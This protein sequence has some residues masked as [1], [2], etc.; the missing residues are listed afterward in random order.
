[1][2]DG[3]GEVWTQHH[4][5]RLLHACTTTAMQHRRTRSVN[6]HTDAVSAPP[7]APPNPPTA[8]PQLSLS[9]LPVAALSR[10]A[11]HYGLISNEPLTPAQATYPTPALPVELTLANSSYA[12]QR[13]RSSMIPDRLARRAGTAAADLLNNGVILRRAGS[14]A[15]S[16]TATPKPGE[17]G[18][19][20]LAA[21]AVLNAQKRLNGLQ[22]GEQHGTPSPGPQT[23][24][25]QQQQ[26]QQPPTTTTTTPSNGATTNEW[27][28]PGEPDVEELRGMTAYDGGV[29]QFK[30]R[31][32][33]LVKSHWDKV[34]TV[35]EGETIIN[36]A[37]AVRMRSECRSVASMNLCRC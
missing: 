19:D 28:E 18:R 35:K 23:S 14:A 21:T 29:D 24:S 33:A 4:L 20:S 36:F 11:L 37:Y 12:N 5:S 22:P 34:T 16:A 2:D 31:L 26:Q 8:H 7:L 13:K 1:M 25:D 6:N 27:L 17:H 9:T 10:Y 30:E 3:M 15:P 32:G